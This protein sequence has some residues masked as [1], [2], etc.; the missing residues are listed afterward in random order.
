MHRGPLRCLVIALLVGLAPMAGAQPDDARER[1]ARASF[2]AG[3]YR[4]ALEG[5]VQLYTDRPHPT[6]LR[7]IGRCYQNLGEPDKAISSFRDY[8]R[9]ARDLPRDQ[10]DVIEGYIR[11]MEDLKRKRELAARPP[12]VAPS[13]P[14]PVIVEAPIE[15]PPPEPSVGPGRAVAYVVGAASAVA[16]GAGAVF[17][18]RAISQNHQAD[19]ECPL[20]KCSDAGY[21]YG[22]RALTSARLADVLIG[23]GLVGAGVAAFLWVRSGP[24]AEPTATARFQITPQLAP[25]ALGLSAGASW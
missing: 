23:A 24:P 2:A 3:D 21:Q 7:N 13:P 10:R 16:I 15:P 11:E 1:A 20:K 19:D 12:T 22:E 5:Y 17:G 4:R 9:Q 25:H 8:L 14:P 18:L 6:F